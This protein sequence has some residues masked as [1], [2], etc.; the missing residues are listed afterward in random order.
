VHEI[1]VD[2]WKDSRIPVNKSCLKFYLQDFCVLIISHRAQD[3]G[4]NGL[5]F[6]EYHYVLT[7]ELKG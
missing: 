4:F 5:S 6:Q 1:L 3:T 2:F 7:R